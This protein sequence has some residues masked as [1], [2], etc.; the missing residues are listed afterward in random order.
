M[1]EPGVIKQR[2]N[3]CNYRTDAKIRG[4]LY[5]TEHDGQFREETYHREKPDDRAYEHCHRHSQHRRQSQQA[6]NV[7]QVILTSSILNDA[8]PVEQAGF[9]ERMSSDI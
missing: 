6:R 9:G 4:L 8:N 3:R 2:E 1:V 7:P 5:G